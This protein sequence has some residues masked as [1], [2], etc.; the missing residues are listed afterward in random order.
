[1]PK[2]CSAV[3]TGSSGSISAGALLPRPECQAVVALLF[4]NHCD[5]FVSF[6]SLLQI[7][8]LSST[9]L[10]PK[11]YVPLRV[12]PG[13]WFKRHVAL[14]SRVRPSPSVQA[15]KI[16]RDLSKKHLQYIEDY[17][18][19][20][21]QRITLEDVYHIYTQLGLKPPG[22]GQDTSSESS[23]E[24]SEPYRT[25][26]LLPI[27][28]VGL[29][30]H[31]HPDLKIRAQAFATWEDMRDE[32]NDNERRQATLANASSWGVENDSSF[33]D[34][35]SCTTEEIP[36]DEQLDESFTSESESSW[37]SECDDDFI[38]DDVQWDFG[39]EDWP[40]SKAD[41]ESCSLF[42]EPPGGDRCLTQVPTP[43][44]SDTCSS[45]C[46]PDLSKSQSVPT[47]DLIAS[48]GS[49][50]SVDPVP[51]ASEELSQV[52]SD[53]KIVKAFLDGIVKRIKDSRISKS[54]KEAEKA[55]EEQEKRITHPERR[56]PRGEERGDPR[57]A[58]RF[59]RSGVLSPEQ[60]EQHILEKTR[61]AH[62][63]SHFQMTHQYE[64]EFGMVHAE[65]V[66]TQGVP[67]ANEYEWTMTQ[68]KRR[69]RF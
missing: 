24:N 20:L 66:A 54:E 13:C 65:P 2:D 18:Q 33:S 58:L 37:G 62:F 50:I 49:P 29:R 11:M 53:K 69:T 46:S 60:A 36:C 56:N 22:T 61:K 7:C 59:R 5:F 15:M 16:A 40:H 1:M 52:L 48:A 8:L 64:D 67:P 38:D 25:G 14:D 31:H 21:V 41:T 12:D 45:P 34:A 27:T 68:R 4:E 9:K 6:N 63:E 26:D 57:R 3:Q 32:Y 28:V 43:P 23:D 39:G 30:S 10:F 47:N 17:E 19:E 51:S 42:P 35:G 55:A 44:S